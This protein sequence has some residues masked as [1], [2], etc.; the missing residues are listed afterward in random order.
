MV[1]PRSGQRLDEV[2][3]RHWGRYIKKGKRGRWE[4]PQVGWGRGR[5]MVYKN[6]FSSSG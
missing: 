4:E 6:Y 2:S 1:R 5:F 3:Q